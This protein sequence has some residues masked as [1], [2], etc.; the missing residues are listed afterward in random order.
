MAR[1]IPPYKLK[2]PRDLFGKLEREAAKLRS[3]P[4]GDNVFNFMVTAYHLVDW[5]SNG[6]GATDFALTADIDA[7]LR[8]NVYV[9]ICRDVCHAS[10]H[11]GIDPTRHS[12]RGKDKAPVVKDVISHPGETHFADWGGFTPR[13]YQMIMAR[14]AWVSVTV[15]TEAYDLQDVVRE[16]LQLYE[17]FL[18]S[19]G[20]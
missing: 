16:V 15:D 6:P 4:S 12:Y 14:G 7:T 19:H 13:A 8:S 18:S 3:D 20:L 11:F 2:T 9:R 17:D 1:I 5:L 10:K